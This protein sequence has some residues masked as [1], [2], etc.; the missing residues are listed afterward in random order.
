MK[1]SEEK[2]SLGVRLENYI[3]RQRIKKIIST[4]TKYSSINATILDLGCGTEP[5]F[6]FISGGAK[7]GID[8]DKYRII[9]AKREN[10]SAHFLIA[11]VCHIPIRTQLS[12]IVLSSEVIEHL[13]KNSHN[14]FL[15]EIERCLRNDGF[16]I[17]STPNREDL[18]FKVKRMLK[19]SLRKFSE[20]TEF[21]Q[22]RR[23]QF[24]RIE[25]RM[26]QDMG[27][28]FEYTPKE[29][30][31]YFSRFNLEVVGKRG[32]T[33][34]W[35]PL[36]VFLDKIP[37]SYYLIIPIIMTVDKIIG[38]FLEKLNLCWEFILVAKKNKSKGA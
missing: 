32:I 31:S 26:G 8:L 2:V 17:I 36:I 4:L 23:D 3:Y 30:K 19:V 5:F 37:K 9:T 21:F 28:K 6:K 27:H 12:D 1:L 25:F 33:L 35:Y 11:D 15:S 24:K 18:K 29:L 10:P 14:L 20:G 13:H 16:F 38:L 34:C 7:I 22:L